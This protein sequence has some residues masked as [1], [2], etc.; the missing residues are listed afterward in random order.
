MELED[1]ERGGRR[2]LGRLAKSQAKR[3]LRDGA[4]QEEESNSEDSGC[5]KRRIKEKLTLVREVWRGLK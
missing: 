2:R 1:E 4:S 5:Y 3:M